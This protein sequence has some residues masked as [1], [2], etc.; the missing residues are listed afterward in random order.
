MKEPTA[1]L[2][3][4]HDPM[5]SWCWGFRPV[6]KQVQESLAANVSVQY[7]LGGLAADTQQAMPVSMQETIKETWRNIQHEIPG[8]VFNFNFWTACQPRRSTYPACRAILAAEMQDVQQEK[9]MLLAIQQAYYLH[10]KNPSDNA[11]LLEL[12]SEI[13]L[14]CSQFKKDLV[15]ARCEKRLRNEMQIAASLGVFS[16]PALV[17]STNDCYT[18]ID[19]DYNNSDT[20]ISNILKRL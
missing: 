9:N 7:V 16:F 15:S 17:L 2:Y 11:V 1:R 3:Y 5:C 6:W 13:G 18:A 19:I 14:D 10:A 4:V 8:T 20:I 12:A